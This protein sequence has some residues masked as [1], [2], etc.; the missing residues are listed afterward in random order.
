[1]TDNETVI[2]P[3]SHITDI[4]AFVSLVLSLKKITRN[5]VKIIVKD[6]NNNADTVVR[7][8]M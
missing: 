3:T 8:S 4:F 6:K 1:M 5:R 2:Q 7:E